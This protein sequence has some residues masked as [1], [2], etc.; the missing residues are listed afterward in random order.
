MNRSF[1]VTKL[2][3]PFDY[4]ESASIGLE[5][6]VIFAKSFNAEIF[7]LHILEASTFQSSLTHLF[8][9]V[10]QKAEATSK[11][12]LNDIAEKI[13]RDNDVKITVMT[14]VGKTYKMIS[15]IATQIEADLIFMGTHGSSGSGYSI[16]SN[17]TKVVQEAPCPVI[18]VQNHAEKTSYDTII[19]PLDDSPESRQKVPFAMEIAKKYRAK[20]IVAALMSSS[21]QDY[22]RKFHLKIDQVQ[23]YLAEHGCESIS[24]I[25]QGDLFKNTMKACEEYDG[26]LLVIMTEQEPGITG[27]LMGTYANKVINNS[28]I[29]VMTIR[30][31]EID[32]DRITVTF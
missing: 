25:Y 16:G 21:N 10:E 8:S 3:V 13:M 17:T 2:L 26:D 1:H 12:K 30:P 7:L 22:V 28:R 23:D 32:P 20:V 5:H 18:A 14:E 15:T 27:L 4:S 11:E 24:E 6:A 31:A 9:S 29:P 19:L